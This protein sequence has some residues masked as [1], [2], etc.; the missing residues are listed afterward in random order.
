MKQTMQL[1]KIQHNMR[2][3]VITRDGFMG[4]ETRNLV[5]VLV[6]DD[7]QVKRLGLTHRMIASRMIEIRDAGIRG[8]GDYVSVDPHFEVR[9]ESVRGKLPCP[10]GDP[11]LFPKTVTIVKNLKKDK[12]ITY[13]DLSIHTI[14][15]HGFYQGK[16]SLY[17]LE[18]R[19]LMEILEITPSSPDYRTPNEKKNGE[20]E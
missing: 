11:G 14:L 4:N 16:G 20:E 9:V 8:L 12:T 19:D 2:P 10:F 17:R 3:G 5:D 13:T 18:P 7:S 15:V 1:E 6:A